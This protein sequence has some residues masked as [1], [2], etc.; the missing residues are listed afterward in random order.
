MNKESTPDLKD[1]PNPF[2]FGNPVSKK[3]MFI[4]R[5]KEQ[6]DIEYY[7]NHASRVEHSINLAILGERAAGKTSLLNI[8]QIEAIEKGLIP[9][10]VDLNESDVT[11][12]LAFWFKLF[13]EL[14]NT[15]IEEPDK[16]DNGFVYGGRTGK[17]YDTYLDIISSYE[18]PEDKTFCPFTFPSVYAKAMGAQ[19][20]DIPVSDHIL[21]M[22]L[23]TISNEV[24]R[25]IVLLI[26]ECNILSSHRSL[27]EMVRN[28]FMNLPGFMLVFTGTPDLFPLMDEV[29]SPI[30]RQF[31]KI[32]VNPFADIR[33]TRMA[34]LEPLRS[35]S[36]E[37][38]FPLPPEEAFES[39]NSRFPADVEIQELH[40][41]TSGKPYEI[42]LVCHCMF[43]RVQQ[44]KDKYMSLSFDVLQDVLSELKQSHDVDARPIISAVRTL[45]KKQLHNLAFLLKS[46]GITPIHQLIFYANITSDDQINLDDMMDTLDRLIELGIL[47]KSKN[48]AI[49]KG[50]DFDRIVCKYASRQRGV[51]L[52]FEFE[53]ISQ[54]FQQRILAF[55]RKINESDPKLSWELFESI[56]PLFYFGKS[57]EELKRSFIDLW[58][59]I[60]QELNI[61]DLIKRSPAFRNSSYGYL[62]DNHDHIKS[63]LC[64]TQV[65]ITGADIEYTDYFLRAIS[66]T[67][68]KAYD[69][70]K[71]ELDFMSQKACKLGGSV[72]IENRTIQG[73]QLEDIVD[74][75]TS[76]DDAPPAESLVSLHTFNMYNS[77]IIK[78]DKNS[79]L[80]HAR[81]IAK[82][83]ESVESVDSDR[84]NNVG[85]VFLACNEINSAL[86]ILSKVT[87]MHPDYSLAVYN[88][89]LAHLVK[90]EYSAAKDLFKRVVNLESS[91]MKEIR[92][93]EALLFA[94]YSDGKVILVEKVS[95]AQK[96]DDE[97]FQFSLKDAANNALDLINKLL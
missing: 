60:D 91:S 8:I 69:A 50:D 65:S 9:V 66:D 75:I 53:S 58:E 79:A 24:D 63:G 93:I 52:D 30:V 36:Q 47:A 61:V 26:D 51:H 59:Q 85:Y 68:D 62:I 39:K 78:S 94:E 89:G 21:K 74:S 27:L 46:S 3:E 42:Q 1:L 82:F 48:C 80:I 96:Q 71:S 15:I 41:L 22:D 32:E 56:T 83:I 72:Q 38:L 7:L 57:T 10:R 11:T 67:S 4:G 88:F 87:S 37:D 28:T 97:N 20:P 54:L 33:E 14:F 86:D 12:H 2:D 44:K 55:G 45:N 29:F 70:L 90:Q 19:N 49:F 23:T 84:G 34:V 92:T 18:V 76:F 95:R 5:A 31:K 25:T 81:L 73:S 17:I 64:I 77:Y 13:G 35:V 6:E 16:D 43:R 40:D